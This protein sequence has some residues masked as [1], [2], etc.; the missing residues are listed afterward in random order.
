MVDFSDMKPFCLDEYQAAQRTD[1]EF[2]A[3]VGPR[4][5]RHHKMFAVS[6]DGLDISLFWSGSEYFFNLSDIRTPEDMIWSLHHIT[7]KT[8]QHMT[9]KRIGL[10]IEAVCHA[11][12]WKPYRRVRH[13]NEMPDPF[14]SAAQER[15]KIT[16]ALRYEVIRRDGHRCRCCGASVSTGAVLHV[17]HIVAV[18]RGGSSNASNLQTLCS[19]CNQGKAAQ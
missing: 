11:K 16:P 8:W 12:G 14:T 4:D 5:P 1:A 17:D 2:Q 19:A 10:L 18:S 7:K 9:P 6:D 13:A 15:A 3:A